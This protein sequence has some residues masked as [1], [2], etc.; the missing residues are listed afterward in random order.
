MSTRGLRVRTAC[1]TK[2]VHLTDADEWEYLYA[3]TLCG[4]KVPNDGKKAEA[5]N[6]SFEM[7]VGKGIRAATCRNCKRAIWIRKAMGRA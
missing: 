6:E 5:V 1:W 7:T 4:V 3:T 2:K